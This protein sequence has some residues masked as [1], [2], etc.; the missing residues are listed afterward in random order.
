MQLNDESENVQMKHDEDDSKN[1]LLIDQEN[2]IGTK[3]VL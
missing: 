3:I 1:L 2:G